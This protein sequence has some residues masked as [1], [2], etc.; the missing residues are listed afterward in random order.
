M[1]TWASIKNADGQGYVSFDYYRMLK[2]NENNWTNAQEILYQKEIKGEYISA[3]EISDAFPVYKLQYAGPL[4][5]T[6]T[7]YPVQSIDKFS[8]LPLIPSLIKDSP[9][10]DTIHKQM[11]NQGVDYMLFDSGAK[12]SY[13]KSGKNNGD[14]IFEGN[15]TSK[16]VPDFK[17]T[18]NPY[19]VD[20][21][22]NQTEVSREFKNKSTLSTQFRKLF[23]V[24]L[25]ENGT[26]VGSEV[27]KKAQAVLD[28]LERLTSYMR[29]DLLKELGWR[30]VNGKLQGDLET[31]LSYIKKKLEEQGYSKHEINSIETDDGKIDLSTN[32]IAPRLERFLS[33]IHI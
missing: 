11:I 4:A 18:L 3:E 21:L 31:M 8:L 12:R 23:D 25:Y 2:A 5:I 32:P 24:T 1:D 14:D 19:Y 22:K 26:P 27:H 6:G 7:V 29:K 17:F 10:L 33:L 15:D 9:S 20:F 16:L 13:I 28:E 30:E